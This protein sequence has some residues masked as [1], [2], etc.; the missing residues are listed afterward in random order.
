MVFVIFI[1]TT[2]ETDKNGNLRNIERVYI[3][4]VV[5][6]DNIGM[7]I[8]Y[9]KTEAHLVPWIGGKNGTREIPKK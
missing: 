3:R 4:R 8:H 9:S 5:G 7:K 2:F 6:I 1:S